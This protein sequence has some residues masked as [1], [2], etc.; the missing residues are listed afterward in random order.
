MQ[1]TLIVD[2]EKIVRAEIRRLAEWEKYGMEIVGEA[3]NGRAALR[4]LREHPVDLMITDLSMPGLSGIDF[5]QTVRNEFPEL[6][7]VVMTMHQNFE[8]IQQAMRLDVVDYITKTQIEKENFGTILEGILKRLSTQSGIRRF[9]KDKVYFFCRIEGTQEPSGECS[10]LDDGIWLQDSND[11]L[12]NPQGIVQIDVSGL[13]DRSYH[14]TTAFLHDYLEKELFYSYHQGQQR[15]FCRFHSME[16]DYEKRDLLTAELQGTEWILDDDR[17]N[18]ICSQI[19]SLLLSREE[20]LVFLYQP[21]LKCASYQKLPVEEYFNE[22]QKLRWWYQWKIWLDS[23]RKNTALFLQPEN[24]VESILRRAVQYIDNHYTQN[25]DLASM[26]Q[27]TAMSK[28]LFS[29]GFKEIT[30]MSFVSYLRYLRIEHAK[31]LLKESRYSIQDIAIQIGYD[32]ER[33]FRKIF[34]SITGISPAQFRK[35]AENNFRK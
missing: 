33:Y 24:S 21:F 32:D 17:Y 14:D 7:I 26:L 13:Q 8:Y 10:L 16:P 27:M 23:L 3:E 35:E 15:Y 31:K 6:R 34:V 19:P 22:T 12:E 9:S 2:D 11:S 5:L 28:S 20:L 25:L 29:A 1:R 18:R 30:G 4:F